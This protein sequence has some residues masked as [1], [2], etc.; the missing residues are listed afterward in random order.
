LLKKIPA[1]E[2]HE[3][4]SQ[5]K[6]ICHIE[7]GHG[8]KARDNGNVVVSELFIPDPD[9]TLEGKVSDQDHISKVFQI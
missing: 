1:L 8:E 6:K 9:P 5:R 2:F 4:I 7:Q 3:V